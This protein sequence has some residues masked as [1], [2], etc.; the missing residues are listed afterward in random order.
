MTDEISA[1]TST[2]GRVAVELVAGRTYTIELRGSVTADG[3][4]VDPLLYG[5]NDAESNLISRTTNDE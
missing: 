2:S 5:I 4:F 1:D 3:A